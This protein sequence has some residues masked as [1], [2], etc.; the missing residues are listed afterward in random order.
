MPAFYTGSIF[1]ERYGRTKVQVGYA[2]DEAVVFNGFDSTGAR[3]EKFAGSE[4]P[5]FQ[6]GFS[7]DFTHGP[8]HLTTLLDWR[9]GGYLANLSQTYLEDGSGQ[10]AIKGGNF[11]NTVMDS[12]DEAQF[13]KGFGV[14]LEHASFAKLREV[15]FSYDLSPRL[16]EMMFRG[17]AR[18]ARFGIIGSEPLHVDALPRSRPRSLELRRFAAEPHAGSGAVSAVAVVSCS[19]SMPTSNSDRQQP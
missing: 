18:N 4:S 10:S 14:F 9:H 5:D 11:A 16:T 12:T 1:S 13:A 3:H 7:N 2:P 17:A 19:P 6:M 15:T 8:F